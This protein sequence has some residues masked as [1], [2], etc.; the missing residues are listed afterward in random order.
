MRSTWIRPAVVA[1]VIVL[2]SGCG[3]AESTVLSGGEA[4]APV[5]S[6]PA[7]R[8]L[9]PDDPSLKGC[10]ADWFEG[11]QSLPPLVDRADVIVRATALSSTT[12]AEMWGVGYRTTLRVD[13]VLKGTPATTVTVLESACPV[14]HGG[15]KDWLLFLSPKP[16]DPNVFQVPG[17]IQG[18]FPIT[19]GRMAPLYRDAYLVRAYTGVGA[20]ELEREVS[21]IAPIDGDAAARLRS[22]GWTLATKRSVQAYELRPAHDFGETRLPPRYEIPFE[23]YARVAAVTGLDLRPF[24]GQEI[25]EFQFLLERLTTGSFPYP[26]IAHLIYADRRY[27]G[28][29]VQIDATQVFRLA[30]RAVALATTPQ[31]VREP[32]WP[33]RYPGGVNVVV[34]YGLAGASSVYTKSIDR[35]VSPAQPTLSDV[36]RALDR[37]FATETPPA[38]GQSYWPIGFVIGENR[39][40]FEY[41]PDAGLLVQREDGYA[42]R[43]DTTF[44][45]LI[46][47]AAR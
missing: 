12:S 27:V 8:T 2:F 44:A 4:A 34:E 47:A 24:G 30:D 35:S 11:Y 16:D 17:G 43:P 23:G 40:V 42:I 26:P 33:N 18:A 31:P 41:Y 21:A 9:P 13:R 22:A 46:G 28:G 38:R 25:E 1:F 29:W 15:P 20:A 19:E 39:V 45:R 7:T 36:V 3:T 32:I 5:A 37:I 6:A 10:M 14:V